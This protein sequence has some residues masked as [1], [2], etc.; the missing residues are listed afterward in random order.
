[1]SKTYFS[2]DHEYIKVE[3]DSATI[4]ISNYAQEQLGDIVF[5]LNC[6]PSALLSRR[7]TRLPLSNR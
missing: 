7:A 1:M 2:T 4:G 3:G 6:P 5:L